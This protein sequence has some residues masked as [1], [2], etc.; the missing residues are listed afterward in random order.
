MNEKFNNFVI[1][2]FKKNFLNN[3][4][5]FNFTVMNLTLGEGMV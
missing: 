2:N 3:N 5:F 4:I 1:K